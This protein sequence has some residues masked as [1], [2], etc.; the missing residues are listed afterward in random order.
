MRRKKLKRYEG[1]YNSRFLTFSCFERRKLL[2]S[3]KVRDEFVERLEYVHSKMEIDL[4][5]WVVMPNHVHLIVRPL[6]DD[7]TVAKYLHFLK[8]TFAYRQLKA[9]RGLGLGIP[10]FWQ[11]GGGYD[12]N[13]YS[14]EEFHEKTN[15]IHENPIRA[16][17]VPRP[18]DWRW[19]S[20]GW[21]EVFWTQ[22]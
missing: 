2:D 10:Q 17:L 9:L 18:E 7:V 12:R 5:Y 8:R 13:L 3:P 19:S 16:G 4:Y 1:V 11:A 20:A 22:F 21:P 15:Y 6:S 14:D